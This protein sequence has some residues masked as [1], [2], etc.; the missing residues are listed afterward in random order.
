MTRSTLRRWTTVVAPA[1]LAVVLSLCAP[2]SSVA[3]PQPSPGAAQAS[4]PE[5]QT[6]TAVRGDNACDDDSSWGG[7]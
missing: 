3:A 2:T 5:T 4:P 6:A 1:A 7:R